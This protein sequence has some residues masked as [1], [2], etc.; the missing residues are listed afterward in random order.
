[1][2]DLQFGAQEIN[3]GMF[4]GTTF[5][6]PTHGEFEVADTVLKTKRIAT[7]EQWENALGLAKRR[8]KPNSRPRILTYDF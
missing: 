3:K 8:A 2:S 1:V 6:C 5:R 7:T 4:D